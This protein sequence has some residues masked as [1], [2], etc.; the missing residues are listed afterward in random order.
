MEFKEMVIDYQ[1]EIVMNC[2]YTT[3]LDYPMR[4]L[5]QLCNSW[6]FCVSFREGKLKNN[7]NQIFQKNL[8]IRIV[9]YPYFVFTFKECIK[10]LCI[11]LNSGDDD[12]KFTIRDLGVYN[13]SQDS[14]QA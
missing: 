14:R 4:V 13:H 10:A 3:E 11:H 12:V 9:E 6:E 1:F 2:T 8:T 5:R 7:Q